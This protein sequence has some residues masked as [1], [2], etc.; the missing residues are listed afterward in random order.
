MRLGLLAFPLVLLATVAQAQT[1]RPFSTFRQMHGETRLAARLEYAAG[2][3]RL[4]SGETGELYRMDLSY[5]D[6]RF[7]PLSDFD[8][9]R[10]AVALGLRAAGD[11]G[12][13]V[14]SRNQLEQVAAVAFSP[15]V[16]LS[17]EVNLGAADAELDLGGLRV[18]RLDVQTGASRSL[19][20]FSKPNL[21]R[22]S[23]ASFSAGAAELTIM[24]LGNSRCDEID[25]EGGMGKVT[26][27]FG[28]SW[29]SNSRVQ[30]QMAVG[31]LTLRLP[32]KIGVRIAM[33][34]FLSS[35]EP[36]GLVRRGDAFQ[37]PNYDRNQRHL[38]L[39]LTAA[40]GGVKVVWLE[41]GER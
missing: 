9:P 29:S 23:R 24:G 2:S 5:D 32:R 26:L 14:V 6:D 10:G 28:G 4:G 39:E 40:M 1:M 34:R 37:S 35:F 15:R 27:D 33:D 21:V 30:V 11:A 8:S 17:L 38:D 18:S 3:L 41:D 20:R 16:D 22:C 31:E 12:V 13:R 19:V 7:A 25:F 36:A